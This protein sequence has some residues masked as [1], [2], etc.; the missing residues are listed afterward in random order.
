M[1]IDLKKL[2]KIDL[3][4][5]AELITDPASKGYFLLP[6]GQEH[7]K[8]LAYLSTKFDGVKI[9]DIGTYH[10]CSALALSY[11]P[12]NTVVSYDISDM[13][14]LNAVPQNVTFKLVGT[15][16]S[17]VLESDL[18]MLDTTHDGTHEN[19]VID[20]LIQNNW[21]GV[22]ILDDI[23]H[24]PEQNKLWESITMEKEDLTSIGHWSGTGIIYF[25]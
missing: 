10:G 24:F 16:D 5:L 4:S 17:E 20:F 6:E 1:S 11:N 13:V 25:K 19:Q 7:Y 14:K 9:A 21:K 22:L 12:K 15:P 18:I 3:S 8:L 2:A 23:H